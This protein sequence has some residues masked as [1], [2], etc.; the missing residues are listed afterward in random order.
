MWHLPLIPTKDTYLGYQ[1]LW[2]SGS[3]HFKM[4]VFKHLLQWLCVPEVNVHQKE[5]EIWYLLAM[6]WCWLFCNWW[7]VFPN[8]RKLVFW[9]YSVWWGLDYYIYSL[10]KGVWF[11]FVPLPIYTFKAPFSRIQEFKKL[12]WALLC[13][14]RGDWS[15]DKILHYSRSDQEISA[16]NIRGHHHRRYSSEDEV[17]HWKLQW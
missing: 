13:N 7:W 1:D 15:N 2:L 16:L 6:H 9:C 17:F 8:G 11:L 5:L 14:L 3:E 10:H 12:M 4:I